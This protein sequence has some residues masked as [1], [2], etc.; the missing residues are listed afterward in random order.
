[1][2]S[3]S[4]AM[5][6]NQGP[7]I[8][9]HDLKKPSSIRSRRLDHTATWTLRTQN[10]WLAEI[11]SLILG[12]LLDI[13]LIVVLRVYD[14]KVAPR[15]GAV[16]NGA[17]TLNTIVA[18][19]STG[20]KAALLYPVA[21]CISQLKWIWFSKDYRKLSD[22]STFDNASRGIIG[23]FALAWDTRLRSLASVGSFLMLFSLAIDPMSQQLVSLVSQ[24]I[25]TPINAT[26]PVAK[27]FDLGEGMIIEGT[28]GADRGIESGIKGAIQTGLYSANETIPDLTPSCMTGNCTFSSYWSLAVCSSFANVSSHLEKVV[29]PATR[30]FDSDEYRYQLTNSSYI[31]SGFGRFNSSSAAISGEAAPQGAKP[32]NFT[33]SIA[34]RNVDY[35]LADIFVIYPRGIEGQIDF[36]N[37][38]IQA[39]HTVY[40]AVE[41]LL[42]WCA[43][44]FTTEVQNGISKTVR[45]SERR[46][47]TGEYQPA[48]YGP[49]PWE[50]LFDVEE[51]THAGIVTF[52]N[53]T[54]KGSVEQGLD[55]SFYASSDAA[56]ALFE[57]YNLD[58]MHAAD[59]IWSLSNGI[60]GTNQTGLEL[61]VTNIATGMT[62]YVRSRG[63][64]VA[65][66]TTFAQVIV[67]EIRWSWIAAHAAFVGLSL[68]LLACAMVQQQL[69]S[70]KVPAWKSSSLALLHA[71]DPSLKQEPRGITNESEMSAL[72][73]EQ[74][75]RLCLTEND[76]WRLQSVDRSVGSVTQ[77]N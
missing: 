14:G 1:M 28:G 53:R 60:R 31:V 63:Y 12:I 66:G 7:E 69:S 30:E 67:V 49:G 18:I 73:Q 55:Q 17:L 23:G 71:M 22:M 74:H 58:Q 59:T 43:Q 34:F 42:E 27:S 5:V 65:N 44:E 51:N 54:L 68:L 8:Q 33:E 41:V 70:I 64:M 38:T 62:N 4:Y 3:P 47:F 20:S 11:A 6:G 72:A 24:Q 35:P 39:G 76:G 48:L 2:V 21:E 10:G 50:H 57:P 13:A 77:Y 16:F 36:N 37:G 40:G 61:T 26:I 29:I 52:L 15:F 25:S 56:Q 46:N 75:V 9:Q 19:L 45:H 32:F